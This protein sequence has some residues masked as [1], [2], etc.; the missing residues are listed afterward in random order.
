MNNKDYIPEEVLMN[1]IFMIYDTKV[2][3]DSD[4]AEL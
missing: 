4:L 1:K 3:I 2:M